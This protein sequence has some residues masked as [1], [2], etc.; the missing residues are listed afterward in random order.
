MPPEPLAV[1]ICLS[2]KAQTQ[3]RLPRQI[4]TRA[5]ESSPRQDRCAPSGL[6]PELQ[7]ARP[8]IAAELGIVPGELAGLH[9]RFEVVPGAQ[10]QVDWGDEGR[11]LTH[12]GDREGLLLPH[13]AV[14]LAGP[15]PL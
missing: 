1:L 14:L 11:I 15:V 7:E 3:Y 2:V 9:R 10:A 6:L 12:M 5:N 8:R 13:G 4:G